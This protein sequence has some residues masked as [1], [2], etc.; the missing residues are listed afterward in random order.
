M[1]A[2]RPRRRRSYGRRHSLGMFEARRGGESRGQFVAQLALAIVSGGL[3]YVL[4]DG[5]D[6]FLATY[7]PSSTAAKPTDKFTSDGAGTL[8]NTLNIAQSP[9]LLRIG[10][11]LGVTLLPAVAS[12]FVENPF[13]RSSLEGVAIG[14]GVSLFKTFWN[15]VVMGSWLKPSTTDTTSLQKSFIAR[16]YPAEVAA[17]INLSQ[18]QTSASGVAFGALSQPPPGYQ[19][20]YA[21]QPAAPPQQAG[22]GQPADVGPFALAAESP[23][24]SSAE[25]LR[26][27][28]GVAAE[29]PYASSAESLR[30]QAGVAAESPYASPVEALRKQA[31][32][33][34]GDIFDD[35]TRTVSAVIPGTTQ[36]QAMQAAAHAVTTPFDIVA[37]LQRAL[38][39]VP[40][41]AL[42]ECAR[43]LHPRIMAVHAAAPPAAPPALQRIVEAIPGL[44]G[45]AIPGEPGVSQPPAYEPGPP[46]GSGPGPQAHTTTNE[47]IQGRDCACLGDDNQ[48]LGFIGDAEESEQLYWGG[49]SKAA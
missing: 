15:N 31:W 43:H 40:I 48:F 34:V 37:A 20:Q 16:L 33:G 44:H 17:A 27:Q 13:I 42:H 39:H 46:P 19:Q 21:Q 36:Q 26:R 29:S 7:D 28:A 35:I 1:E 2:R 45:S 49:N 8:A 6:R 12:V 11:G 4:A 9:D 30:R 32:G 22:V 24:A 10:A 3:G 14:A 23:Y 47:A 18:K 5:L 41:H 25:S 38:P